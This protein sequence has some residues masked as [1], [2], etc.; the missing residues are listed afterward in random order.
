MN[1]QSTDFELF[2]VPARFAQD[3]A[4]LD[5]RWKEL[6]RQV[7]PD[8]FAA[9]GPAAQRLAMQWSV[10]IN[11]AYQ[12]LRDPLQRARYLCELQGQSVGAEDNTAM[13]PQFLMQQMQWLEAL[14]EAQSAQ[15]LQPIAH[16]VQQALDETI[17]AVAQA[18]DA[19][20]DAQ[21]AAE[22]IR[23]WM[24]LARFEQRLAQR[25]RQL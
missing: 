24:F 20:G 15:E 12:R 18:L 8:K 17:Q 16:E 1:L 11:Q 2:A 23:A 13:P 3:A 10:R 25:Q 22:H 6:Q 5:A 19:K 14:D 7:H 21:A 9:E 4:A